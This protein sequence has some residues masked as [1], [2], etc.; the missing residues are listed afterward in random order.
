[1]LGASFSR[2]EHLQAWRLM[3]RVL[4]RAD[5]FSTVSRRQADALLG[6][7]ALAGRAPALDFIHALPCALET[8]NLFVSEPPDR[9]ALLA[10]AGLPAG[11]LV[12]LWSGGF[13]AWADPATLLEGVERAMDREPRL[14]LVAT[15][16]VLPGYL[17][18]VYEEFLQRLQTSRHAARLHALGW[19]PREEAEGWLRIADLALVVDRPCAETRLGGRNRLL[20]HAAARCPVLASRG[21]EVVEEMEAARAL[22]AFPSG[23]AD[24]MALA[25]TRLLD[26][27]E[28]RQTLARNSLVLAQRRFT[29]AASSAPWLAFL[30]A[31][32]R[33]PAAP[34]SSTDWIA[35][36]LDIDAR[37]AQWTELARL[38]Q[39][40]R[41]KLRRLLGARGAK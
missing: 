9:A 20:Y 23:N 8:L 5:A 21:A 14:H 28:L 34:D 25:L 30:A 32:R 2:D 11:A 36:Y 37:D 33:L 15:G 17:A 27:V 35:R 31:P 1:M 3:L 22:E 16:G 38:R 24:A 41:G 19:R 4:T 12:A 39:G 29:F 40:W 6:Q 18:R 10:G 26:N 7:L 13:N